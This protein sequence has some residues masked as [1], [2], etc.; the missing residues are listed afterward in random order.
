[1][2]PAGHSLMGAAIAVAVVPSRFRFRAKA[3]TVLGFVAL[4]NLPDWRLPGWGHERYGISHSLFVNL[5]TIAAVSL[6]IVLWPR[7]RRAVGGLA[8]V[9]GGAV[10]WLSHPFLDA[11]YNHG[12]G[13]AMFWPFSSAR[14]RLTLPWFETLRKPL[15]HFDGHSAR[16]MAIEL[17]VYGAIFLLVLLIRWGCNARRRAAQRLADG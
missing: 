7:L 13:T 14:L 11:T 15:P 1:M 6:L 8:V 5:A 3:V 2:T 10:A 16:V 9:I 4:A 12:K 17:A